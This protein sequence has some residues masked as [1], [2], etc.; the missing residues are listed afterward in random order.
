MYV[1]DIAV[2]TT[3]LEGKPE[4]LKESSA[5]ALVEGN[6]LLGPVSDI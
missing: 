4:I 6:N 3:V 5:A 1:H 2:G